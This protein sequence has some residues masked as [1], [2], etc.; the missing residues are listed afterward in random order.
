MYALA[1]DL[2]LAQVRAKLVDADEAQTV[3]RIVGAQ[4]SHHALDDAA[5]RGPPDADAATRPSARSGK[6][7]IPGGCAGKCDACVLM[8]STPNLLPASGAVVG[9][10]DLAR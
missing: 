7:G 6:S 8:G 9:G 3:E 2:D 4:P 5:D 10:A 1:F